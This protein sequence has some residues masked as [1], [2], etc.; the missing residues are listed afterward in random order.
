MARSNSLPA[1]ALRVRTYAEL[2]GF[3]RAFADGHL[4]LLILCGDPGIGK[5]QCVRH[6]VGDR[7]GWV[8]G[9]ASAFGI[10]L[11]AFEHRG[12]PIVL[13]DIDGLYRDRNGVR[14]LKA[15]CQADR[16]KAV[17]W[18]TDAPDRHGVPRRF[19]TTSR[20]AVIANE[21]RSLNADVAALE[22]RGHALSFEPAA[23]EVHRR[24]ADWFWDQDVFDFVADHLHLV[25]GHSLR[26]YVLAWE[27][28]RAGLDW[29][30]GVLGR[31]LAGTALTV[32]RLKA[33]P[34]YPTEEDRVRAFVASGVGCRATYFNHARR[35]QPAAPRPEIKLARS[36]PPAPPGPPQ[37]ILDLLRRRFGELGCG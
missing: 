23:A 5:S 22:D 6:A 27:L 26:T 7:V 32:A 37:G 14:L 11:R 30:R 15:L 33:D 13:D 16:E 3:A 21:W 9:N 12:E 19:T 24:A 1:H 28:K 36:A 31:C 8:D 25:A 34:A 17:G 35:L 18:H 29:R 10:Y 4:N 20:V 2:E